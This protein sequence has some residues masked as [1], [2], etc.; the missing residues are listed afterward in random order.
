M[1]SR[2]IILTE[3]PQDKLATSHFRMTETAVSAPG[4][5]QVLLRTLY[6]ALDAASRAWMQGATYRGGLRA[7]DV[8]AG[9]ALAEVVETRV[10]HL[11][12]GDLVFTETGWQT[13]A[14]VS[15]DTL[16][17]LPR[18]EPLTHL[19]SVYGVPGLTAYFGLLE[20]ARPKP[21]DTVV[22]SAAAGAVGS[23]AGQ[24]ARIHGCRTVGIAGGAAKCATL[25][26]TFGFDA[27]VDYKAG[28]LDGALDAA[29]PNGIDV[30]FDNV[31]GEVL[32]ACLSQMV[33][34]GRIACCGAVSQYDTSQLRAGP[35]GVPGLLIIKSLTI[36]GFLLSDFREHWEA[37][38]VDLGTWV[39]LGKLRVVEDVIEGFEK[40][41]E[42][43]VGL[44][45]GANVGKRMIKVAGH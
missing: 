3:L 43:L 35:P 36:R 10:P 24:I 22:I 6:I 32:D 45:A 33:Y 28:D 16:T 14:V 29:C 21:G 27:A 42:A 26:S 2:Q 30:Y 4:E 8:M 7:G 18:I 11:A 41:P 38:L 37:A 31:G 25:T 1:R 5:G 23:I 34:G 15:G 17:K 12:V 9:M 40:L 13:L 19:V 39:A 44:M 20:I